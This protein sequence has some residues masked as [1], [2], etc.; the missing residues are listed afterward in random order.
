M[1]KTTRN[2]LIMLAVLVVLG[3]VTAA[4]L[5]IQPQEEET[6][7][8]A[9]ES[10]ASTEAILEKEATE[11][12]AISVENQEGSFRIVP[13]SETDGSV[14]FT[15][16][17]YGGYNLNNAT[18]NSAAESLL[19]LVPI[20]E[21]GP[22]DDLETFGL[23]GDQAVNVTLEYKDGGSDQ[24]VLGS[25]GGETSG[26]Y[27]L[28]DGNV[29]IVSGIST[30]LYGS[31]YDF[32]SL[33]L[34]AVPDRYESSDGTES[35][36][37]SDSSESQT[38]AEDLMYSVTLSGT[39]FPETIHIEYDDTL[40]GMYRITQPFTA[41]SGSTKF[42]DMVTALKSLD[43]TDVA[44]AGLTDEVLEEYGLLEPYAKIEF[45]MNGSEHTLAVSARDNDGNRYLTADRNDVVYV[46][47][48]DLVSAWAEASLLDMR[49]SYVWL[50]NIMQV[51]RLSL[52][53]DGDMVYSYDVTRT[54]DEEDT[55][56]SYELT[57][58]NAAGEDIDYEGCYHTFYKKLLSITVLSTDSAE[59]AD[60]PA[61]RVEYS[62][63]E[64]D[65]DDVVE[66]CA[67]GEDRYAAVLN[68]EFSGLVRKSEVDKLI[69]MI[70]ELDANQALEKDD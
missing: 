64:R 55:S 7:S 62:Y 13:E 4:L 28:K 36:D 11:V 51:E 19:S 14:T 49:M 52:T 25:T 24:L 58:K 2:I 38:V 60:P 18:I 47:T 66:F 22:Q 23:A 40:T 61:L 54:Q 69:E 26:R 42:N 29:S 17:G 27:V 3:G 57:I 15:I 32:F 39:H 44:A 70:P 46:V 48:D 33:Y 9:P 45:N 50:P 12:A 8:S 56:G 68:G 1:K 6:A 35:S 63:F 59:Y 37:V 53:L 43:A 34:Y 16:E 41:E 21:L 20:K 10:S 31:M 30:N 65:E 5:F 67:V